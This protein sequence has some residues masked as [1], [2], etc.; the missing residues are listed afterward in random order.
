MVPGSNASAAIDLILIECEPQGGAFGIHGQRQAEPADVTVWVKEGADAEDFLF[1]RGPY[2]THPFPDVE[3]IIVNL[4]GN[5]T[6][7]CELM[8]ALRAATR[9]SP[10]PILVTN[11]PKDDAADAR[12]QMPLPLAGG[13]FVRRQS[14]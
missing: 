11:P 13:W 9:T 5:C 2:A 10:P 7:N 12:G 3:I 14:T 6:R 4:N 1:R 8:D